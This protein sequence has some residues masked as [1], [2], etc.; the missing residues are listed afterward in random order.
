MNFNG[1]LEGKRRKKEE[2]E[3]KRGRKERKMLAY[4][5]MHYGFKELVVEF[6]SGDVLGRGLIF[7]KG[8]LY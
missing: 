3:G 5:L 4:G 8:C 6:I 7:L 1:K 2:G